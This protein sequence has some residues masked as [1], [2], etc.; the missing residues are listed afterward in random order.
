[1]FLFW[2][3]CQPST[4]H[5]DSRPAVELPDILL[6]SIDTL[7]AD[8]IG[9]YGDTKAM[10]PNIDKLA[11]QSVLF[12]EAHTVTPLTLPAHASM[13]T[14]VLP[15]KHGVR[16]NAG[17]VLSSEQETIA[18][19]ATALGYNTAAFISAF[20]LD[21]SSG[22]DQGFQLYSDPFHPQDLAKTTAQGEA[23]LPGV[24]VIN[25]ATAWWKK[26]KGPRFLFV[27]L[28]EPHTPWEPDRKWQGDPY[29]GDVAKADRL[30]SRLLDTVSQ[31]SWILLTSDHGEA[32]WDEGEREHGLLLQRSVTRIPLLIRPPQGHPWS[33]SWNFDTPSSSVSSRIIPAETHKPKGLDPLLDLELVADHPKALWIS[34]TPVSIIDV[35]TTISAIAGRRIGD[36]VDLRDWPT[37]VREVDQK[38]ILYSETLFPYFHFGWHPLRMLQQG[39]LRTIDGGTSSTVDWLSMKNAE[40]PTSH[41]DE[42]LLRFGSEL[43]PPG[44]STGE[45][46]QALEALGYLSDA[47]LPPMDQSSD[48]RSKMP[49]YLELLT[50]ERLSTAQRILR[51]R[52]FVAQNP[53]LIQAQLLLSFSL[54]EQGN[55]AEALQVLKQLLAEHPNHQTALN[56]AA[57]ICNELKNY[58]EALSYA[59]ALRIQNPRDAR[60]YRYAAAIYVAQEQPDKVLEITEAGL[61]IAPE[62]PNLLYLAGLSDVFTN[63]LEHFETHF[64]KALENGTRANDIPLWLAVGLQ[65]Q[66]KIDEAAKQ[67][68]RA[69]IAL[70]SD[71][72]PLYYA[73]VMLAD[74]GRC[75][76]AKGFLL[77]AAKR[78]AR[79]NPAIQT[80][81]AKCKISLD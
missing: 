35:A 78:G 51:L 56:N 24:E 20:V 79:I 31:D 52:A 64:Q 2:L 1:M 58:S 25:S 53:E 71:I 15:S 12:R 50:I 41:I 26:T 39:T 60:G 30:L 66:G 14:G 65:R 68:E 28:Y 11:Q 17:Y 75:T 33:D 38:R 42:L 6:I 29:R 8:R 49:I 81:L 57:L 77:N 67:Y 7:R 74:A 37:L 70:P 48:P 18:E 21:S 36:G 63:R 59:E 13:L 80:A 27:H 32:L 55:Q 10:T 69:R 76:E 72:R 19:T 4:P 9:A 62:D 16:D 3:S 73:G 44:P 34:E 54:S 45:Q 46:A 47:Q 23:Q 40:T 43:V 22:I 61:S 5:L